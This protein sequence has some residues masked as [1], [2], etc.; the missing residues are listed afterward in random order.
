V[1]EYFALEQVRDLILDA[2][3]SL[4]RPAGGV[5]EPGASVGAGRGTAG[6]RR[7]VVDGLTGALRVWATPAEHAAIE[8]LLDELAD[9]PAAARQPV[10]VYPIRNRSVSDVAAL[11]ERLIVVGILN[12]DATLEP[13]SGDASAA[14]SGG[15]P[16]TPV[17]ALRTPRVTSSASPGEAS[18]TD[19]LKIVADEATSSLIVVGE[20]RAHEQLEQILLMLD[21]RQPQVRLE[22]LM[23]SLTESQTL[24]LGV[25]LQQTLDL[26]GNTLATLSSLFGLGSSNGGSGDQVGTQTGTGGTAVIL[27]PGDFSALVRAL[28][29]VGDGRSLSMPRLVV[30]N[31]EDATLDS[32]RSEPFLSVN[33]SDTVATTT[34][35]GAEEAGTK[36]QLKPQIAEGDHLVIEYDIELSAFVGESADPALPP[37]RQQTTLSS[38]ATVPDGYVIALGGIEVATD[39]RAVASTPG[40]ASIPLLGELFKNRSRSSGSTRF[41]AF[42]RAEILRGHSFD[43]LRAV[44]DEERLRAGID[45]AAPEVQPMVIR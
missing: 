30:N 8:R 6:D 3:P 18:A 25:E 4:G 1:P 7:I 36:V 17:P 39:G 5:A 27:N 24:D 21:I 45:G 40:L 43:G 2:V 38:S 20:P 22:I 31:N 16:E 35:G 9:V 12:A 29:T 42:I 28:R 10:R 23:L 41:Y 37:P 32:V 11:L 13:A 44:S 34:R 14:A 15:G 33:A 26:G 19:R